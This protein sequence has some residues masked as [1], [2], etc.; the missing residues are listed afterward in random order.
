MI[1]EIIL[2]DVQIIKS[3]EVKDRKII[4][5][6]HKTTVIVFEYFWFQYYAQF[7]VLFY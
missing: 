5:K 3:R 1:G 2:R 4:S 6:F 7:H